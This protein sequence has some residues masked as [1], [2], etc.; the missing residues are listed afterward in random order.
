V[1]YSSRV[2]RYPGDDVSL[3]V[4]YSSR[5]IRYPGDDVRLGVQFIRLGLFATQEVMSV[6]MCSAPW[7][8]YRTSR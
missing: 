7:R 1:Q 4:Q 3:Y 2:I 6:I 8:G 5:V